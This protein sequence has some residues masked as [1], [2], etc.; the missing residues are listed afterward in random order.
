MCDNDDSDCNDDV[1]NNDVINRPSVEREGG[2]VR[3]VG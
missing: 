1:N 2:W 3:R